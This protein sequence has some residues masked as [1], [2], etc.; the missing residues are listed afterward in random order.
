[1]MMFVVLAMAGGLG[2]AIFWTV[3]RPDRDHAN[4][5]PVADDTRT[6]PDQPDAD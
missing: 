3:R 4:L 2:G 5:A 1:M 6:A